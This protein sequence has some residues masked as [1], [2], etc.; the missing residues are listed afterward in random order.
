MLLFSVKVRFPDFSSS[1]EILNLGAYIFTPR[2]K[3]KLR[4]RRWFVLLSEVKGVSSQ[5]Y[6]WFKIPKILSLKALKG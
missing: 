4:D 6:T 5:K 3:T 1:G 2:N